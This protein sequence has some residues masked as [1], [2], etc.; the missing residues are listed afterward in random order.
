MLDQIENQNE[1]YLLGLYFSDGHIRSKGKDRNRYGS[2]IKLAIKD[3]QLLI[4]VSKA[5]PELKYFETELDCSIVTYRKAIYENLKKHGMVESKSSIN[6]NVL[7]LPS[8]QYPLMRHFIRGVFDGDGHITYSPHNNARHC[9][10]TM[11]N[12][13]FI[14]QL[15]HYLL[16]CGIKNKF[17]QQI[18]KPSPIRGEMIYWK[19]AAY[20]ITM[21]S[22]L[23]IKRFHDFIYPDGTELFMQRK[24]VK[25]EELF[26]TFFIK[27]FPCPHCNSLN[28]QKGGKAPGKQRIHCNDCNRNTFVPIAV[29]ESNLIEYNRMNSGKPKV[30]TMVIPSQAIQA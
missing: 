23:M 12:Y 19:Q 16:N 3:K 25:F 10:F 21:Y 20:H 1:A 13:F 18:S 5:F 7:R 14:K 27:K 26:Q 28:T 22:N 24:K 8:L 15:N 2:A 17:S 9:G 4:E 11:N 29:Y 6:K 30:K